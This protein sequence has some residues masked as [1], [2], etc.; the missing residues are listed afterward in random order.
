MGIRIQDLPAYGAIDLVKMKDDILEVSKNDGVPGV[1]HY[2]SNG[3]KQLTLEQLSAMVGNL[4]PNGYIPLVGPNY[5]VVSLG[6]SLANGTALKAAIEAAKTAEPNGNDLSAS[7]RFVVFLFPGTYDCDA[8]GIPALGEFVDIVGIGSAE[9]IIIT[10]TDADGTIQVADTNDYILKNITI[11]NGAGGGS[12]T[13]GV[14]QTDN[15]IWDNLILYDFNT[16]NTTFAGKY[17]LIDGKVDSILNGSISGSVKNSAF[18]DYSCGYS[19]TG[20]IS[21]SG[22]LEN[23]TGG[24]FC[25]GCSDK[26]DSMVS[27]SGQ[28]KNVKGVNRCFGSSNLD[29]VGGG[30]A[31]ITMD[32]YFIN[33][34]GADNCFGSGGGAITINCKFIN[35][36]GENNCFGSSGYGDCTFN[37]L[38]Y[39]KNCDA[40]EKS[41]CF[42]DGA[43]ENNGLCENCNATTESFGDTSA[44]GKLLRCTR[45][46]GYG[47][48]SGTIEECTFSENSGV[49]ETLVID[50]GAVLTRSRF[51][52]FGASDCISASGAVTAEVSYCYVNKEL[53]NITNSVDPAYNIGDGFI[54]SYFILYSPNGHR[55]KITVDNTGTISAE[56]LDP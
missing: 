9:D 49:T 24:S 16:E 46:G 53:V 8:A 30:D 6:T 37:S 42:G 45:T 50:D 4:I 47:V 3:S 35:C 10:S 33:C 20:D 13:H 22:L 56:D 40:L 52:Q 41:F 11:K 14:L 39:F 26:V 27:M 43:I 55:Q 5:I 2:P 15:G 23:L 1:P 54:L 12:V 38:A 29:E 36:K 32:A 51:T 48:H 7:N 25:F 34:T 31:D 18:L 28:F 44:T 19:L 17:N 21:M